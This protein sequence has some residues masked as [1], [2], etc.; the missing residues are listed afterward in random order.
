MH[1]PKG[2]AFF[3]IFLMLLSS[4]I[5]SMK[6]IAIQSDQSYQKTLDLPNISYKKEGE[7]LPS[8]S[9][10]SHDSGAYELQQRAE[11]SYSTDFLTTLL[12]IMYIRTL[13]ADIKRFIGQLV[14]GTTLDVNF[15]QF[16]LISGSVS[17]SNSFA[18]SPD[19][20][21]FVTGLNDGTLCMWQTKTGELLRKFKRYSTMI[22]SVAFSSCGSNILSLSEDGVSCCDTVTGDELF[23]IQ[24]QGR[25]PIIST[26]WSPDGNFILVGK[27]NGTVELC[28]LSSGQKEVVPQVGGVG[29]DWMAEEDTY[30]SFVS[31]SPNGAIIL[32]KTKYGRVLL[33]D[34]VT[35]ELLGMIKRDT[36]I[37]TAVFSPNSKALA[38]ASKEGEVLWLDSQTGEV[39][40]V[41][42]RPEEEDMPSR[43]ASIYFLAWSPDGNTIL[44]RSS[45]GAV[46]VWDYKTGRKLQ[47]LK[48]QEN[49]SI[50]SVACS[51]DSRTLLTGSFRGR[52]RLWDLQTGQCIRVLKKLHR[53]AIGL[54]AW[55]PDGKTIVAQSENDTR[56]C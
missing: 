25:P 23:A 29:G 28:S 44:A 51:P 45:A 19:G 42:I 47:V 16:K 26:V 34:A 9:G 15:E 33:W 53:V 30:R 17:N 8:P 2:I 6:R 52:V 10:S 11:L 12:M 14:L 3:G 4:P 48:E 1:Y 27:Y 38:I 46:Y 54:V 32:A 43:G 7:S 56:L 40:T 5:E 55:S 50:F 35:K 39:V 31:F 20:R 49:D 21:A 22:E 37:T 24:L 18:Y 41:A 13:P 36:G